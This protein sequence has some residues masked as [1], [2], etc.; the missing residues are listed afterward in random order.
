MDELYH[1]GGGV[2]TFGIDPYG[3]L[4]ICELSCGDG[5]DLREG[6]FNDGWETYLLKL[7]KKKITRQTKCIHCEIKAMCGMCPANAELE[8]RDP[9]EP[10]DFMCQVAHLRAKAL[11]ISVKPHGE[12]EYCGT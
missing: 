2:H 8:N 10:V 7:R 11:G 5:Y 12:C 1:C 9:E 4:K 3:K 6:S